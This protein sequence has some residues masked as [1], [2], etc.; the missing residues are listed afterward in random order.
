MVISVF[1]VSDYG[2]LL[3]IVSPE[4]TLTSSAAIW[5]YYDQDECFKA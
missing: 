5:T 1:L 3:A 4:N 2:D